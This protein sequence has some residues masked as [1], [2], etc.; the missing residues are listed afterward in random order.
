MKV[1]Q[2]S[3]WTVGAHQRVIDFS[4]EDFALLHAP[5]PVR[6][7]SVEDEVRDNGQ[8]RPVLGCI[9]AQLVIGIKGD[10][11]NGNCRVSK[12]EPDVGKKV[13]L[14]ELERGQVVGESIIR[15]VLQI[16]YI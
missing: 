9:P 13:R 5:D 14:L 7:G 10:S 12:P 2:P 15:S 16:C 4:S 8:K 11:C 1:E 3:D 6:Q